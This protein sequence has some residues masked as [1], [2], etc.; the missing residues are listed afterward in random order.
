[1]SEFIVAVLTLLMTTACEIFLAHSKVKLHLKHNL[2]SI[3][4][5]KF[6]LPSIVTLLAILHF[7]AFLD[8][9][10]PARKKVSIFC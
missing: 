10:T 2:Y 6:R 4:R 7:S 8:T 9:I 5:A 1:M 3:E